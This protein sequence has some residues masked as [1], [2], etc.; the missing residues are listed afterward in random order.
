MLAL[1]HRS[2]TT[3]AKLRLL[4]FAHCNT[5]ILSGQALRKGCPA[6]KGRKQALLQGWLHS[7]VP[8]STPTSATST[9]TGFPHGRGW[10]GP[11]GFWWRATRSWASV[12][13]AGE[14][15]RTPAAARSSCVCSGSERSA[16]EARRRR[17][18]STT[19][20]GS[21]DRWRDG[22]QVVVFDEAVR[23]VGWPS[24]AGPACRSHQRTRAAGS[25]RSQRRTRL[26]ATSNG[27]LSRTDAVVGGAGHNRLVATNCSMWPEQTSQACRRAHPRQGRCGHRLPVLRA[28]SSG[29]CRLPN[30]EVA[31]VTGSVGRR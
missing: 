30:L 3:A 17:G 28:P 31:V 19:P 7:E 15:A 9:K 11:P 6:Q 22:R 21:V 4:W 10:T 1:G 5:P 13:T 20:S 25:A 29:S 27:Q 8:S 26:Q 18:C 23:V 2:V 16:S 12:V 24:A 14:R